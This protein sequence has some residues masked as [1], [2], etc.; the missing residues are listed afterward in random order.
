MYRVLIVDDS[1]TARSLIKKSLDVCGLAITRCLEASNGR[2]ALDI[3]K[4]EAVD[5]VLTDVNM[6]E[7]DGVNLLR[8]I[9]SSPKL[10]DV[11]VVV[12]T[13]L[14]NRTAEQILKREQAVA[15]LGKP[16]S[17]PEVHRLLKNQLHLI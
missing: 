14:K 17:I 10:F 11:P 7:M 9:K 4:N 1:S 6:P 2:E 12:I 13:S 15:V 3:L 5:L 8:R 16:L